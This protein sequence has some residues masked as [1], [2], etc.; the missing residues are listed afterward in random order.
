MTQYF[1]AICVRTSRDLSCKSPSTFL[2]LTRL[3][4]MLKL[5]SNKFT[6][7]LLI[8]L[9]GIFRPE[10]FAKEPQQQ[11]LKI[12]LGQT[13]RN[14]EVKVYLNQRQVYHQKLTTPD[15]A[16]I[17]DAFEIPK[18]KKPFRLTVEINGIKFE[19]SSPKNARE[20]DK[21]D[22]SLLINYHPE[23]EE[24]EIKTKILIVLYD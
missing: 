2:Q 19:K 18:P 4:I 21:E 12:E 5:L 10:A 11:K 20:L 1:V 9:I 13:F 16:Q 23:T 24:I 15:S 6:C 17:T 3:S 8:F 22:Y 14:N 7:L